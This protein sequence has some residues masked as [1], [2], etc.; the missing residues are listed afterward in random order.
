MNRNGNCFYP[1]TCGQQKLV[2]P[3]LHHVPGHSLVQDSS[4]KCRQSN[5]TASTRSRGNKESGLCFHLCMGWL[6]L[7]Y[8]ETLVEGE[9]K[10]GTL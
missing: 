2:G 7:F 10:T 3:K 4:S 6:F 1:D 8:R 5:K 9:R